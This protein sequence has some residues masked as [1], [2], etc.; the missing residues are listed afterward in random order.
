[1]VKRLFAAI[2]KS[3]PMPICPYVFHL[4]YAH[5]TIQPKDKK[6]YMVG[7]SMSKH[8]VEPN[9]EQPA[10]TEDSK[11]KSLDAEEITELLGK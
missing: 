9:E 4:Y 8:K 3:K 6:A 2:E 1:M 7:E 5:K 10:G 11:P